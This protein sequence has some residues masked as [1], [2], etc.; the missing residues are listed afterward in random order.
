MRADARSSRRE[1]ARF[2]LPRPVR[3][4]EG[5]GEG[6]LSFVSFRSS[7]REEACVDLPR[8]VGRGEGQGEG[9]LSLVTSAATAGEGGRHAR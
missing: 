4:G 8:P 6:N 3:R 7:R 9:N 1:E 5:R 2:H